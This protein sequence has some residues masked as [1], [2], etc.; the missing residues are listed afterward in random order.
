ML[1]RSFNFL[2]VPIRMQWPSIL[3][4]V[5]ASSQMVEKRRLK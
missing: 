4:N 1:K 2:N 3:A 5:A